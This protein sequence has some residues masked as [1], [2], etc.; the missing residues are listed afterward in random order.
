MKPISTSKVMR[1]SR[2][3]KSDAKAAERAGRK[4]RRAARRLK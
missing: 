2:Q 1:L 3:A 4:V